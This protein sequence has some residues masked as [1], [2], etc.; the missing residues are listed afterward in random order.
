M[1]TIIAQDNNNCR[2][3]IIYI[4]KFV[5]GTSQLAGTLVYRHNSHLV[6]PVT[7]ELVQGGIGPHDVG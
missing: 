3:L 1:I 5:E 4:L 6:M 7:A 2:D